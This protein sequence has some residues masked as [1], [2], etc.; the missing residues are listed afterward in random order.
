MKRLG[1]GFVAGFIATL[2]FH[3]I[4]LL[5]IA[6]A[7][8]LPIPIWDLSSVPPLGV[9]K[10]ISLAFWGGIWGIGLAFLAPRLP[11]GEAAFWITVAVLGGIL[12]TAVYVLV[13]NPLKGVVVPSGQL[14]TL[15]VVGFIVNAAWGIGA[16]LILRLAMRRQLA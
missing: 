10:V 11:R 1:L 16:A 9:P 15:L 7:A 4:A 8:G 2:V 14:P 5:I 13:V 6:K 3:Q 12:P